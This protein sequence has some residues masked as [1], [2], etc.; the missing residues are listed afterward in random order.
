MSKYI[1]Q[2]A[3]WPSLTWDDKLIAPLLTETRHRQ[4]RLLGRMEGLGFGLQEEANLSTLALDVLKSSE[5]EGELLNAEE[6]RS[7][8]ARRL[9]I[10]TDHDKHV[11]RD[12]EGVVEMVM[13]AVASFRERLTSEKLFGWHS[14]LFP[15]GRSGMYT[16]VVG[17]WRDNDPTDPMQVVSGPMGK[18]RVHFEAP[19]S[20]HATEMMDQ[21]LYWLNQPLA[22]DPVLKAAI[23]HLWFV[24]I[25]PF[26][27]GNGRIGRAIMDR[28]LAVADGSSKRFYSMS[29]Q[30]L[31]ERKDYYIQLE[32]AQKGTLDI[33]AYLNWFLSCLD[34]AILN[35]DEV[36]N[37][38]LNK[39]Q[40]WK[41][42]AAVPLNP[43][44]IKVVNRLL[45][46]FDGK[47]TSSKWA[48]ICK[49][50]QDTALRDITRLIELGMLE[51]MDSGGRSSNYELII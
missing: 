31:K 27:D 33:T 20:A 23:A 21:F 24:T 2:L 47:L 14:A 39:S 46:G 44:Q 34:R 22:I 48:K 13:D 9:G 49:C 18:E 28:Q 6:V 8:I 26:D 45:D 37:I 41:Q 3:G 25:H 19:P 4:G 7:S 12:V 38:I 29:S 16:I 15:T 43:R 1:Y 11:S 51:K 36:L 35:T 17:K 50:S 30:I 40:F 42:H 32:E 5:I 10:E